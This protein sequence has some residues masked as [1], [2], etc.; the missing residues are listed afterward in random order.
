MTEHAAAPG[1]IRRGKWMAMNLAN[2][3]TLLRI[4]SIPFL[5]TVLLTEFPNKEIWGIALFLAAS[6]TDV[7]DGY[8]ARRRRQVTTMGILMDPLADKLLI[9]SAFIILVQLHLVPAWMVVIIIGREF[10]VTGLRNLASTEGLIIRASALGKTKMVFQV[11]AVCLI[12]AGARFGGIWLLLGK[13]SLWLVLV[14][15][16]SSM[17]HYF[18]VF[19]RKIDAHRKKRIRL[20]RKLFQRRQNRVIREARSEPSVE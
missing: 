13:I 14:I 12:L 15:A 9:S 10:A 16:V 1:R 5:V 6:V 8:I 19:W 18:F 7:L 4:F 3:L 2:Y 11:V 20:K 17:V